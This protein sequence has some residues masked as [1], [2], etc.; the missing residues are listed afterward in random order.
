MKNIK[1]YKLFTEDSGGG[2]D[3]GGMSAGG[4]DVG[5]GSGVA[6]VDAGIG[7]MGPVV[8]PQPGKLPG[9]FGTD[10]S[11]DVGFVFGQQQRGRKKR[12]RGNPSEVSDLRD[13]KRTLKIKRVSEL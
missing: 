7:G 1:N 2:G 13:L 9:T 3:S 8:S 4:G 10:G 12:K 5:G 11:G 6:M